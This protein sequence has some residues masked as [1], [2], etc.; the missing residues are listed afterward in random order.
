LSL[1]AARLGAK[2][3]AT[4]WSPAGIERFEARVRAE[5]LSDAEGRV[6]D[7]H[8]LEIDDDTGSQGGS[9]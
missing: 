5:G 4:D 2:V 6:M 1:P 9:C 8:A 7:A 3:L